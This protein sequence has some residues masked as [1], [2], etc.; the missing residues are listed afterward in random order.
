MVR[1]GK[2]GL[3]CNADRALK[4]HW[5][6]PMSIKSG[7]KGQSSRPEMKSGRKLCGNK[8]RFGSSGNSTSKPKSWVL[9][10]KSLARSRG[11]T[12]G[13]VSRLWLIWG[14]AGSCNEWTNGSSIASEWF[15]K[16]SA[17]VFLAF[18]LDD[19]LVSTAGSLCLP[20]AGDLAA[21]RDLDSHEKAD[22]AQLTL[23]TRQMFEALLQEENSSSNY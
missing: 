22:P 5:G 3:N 14:V 11:K 16:G 17:A 19:L 15:S 20:R 21:C 18:D 10:L 1:G 7:S 9:S 2:W 13:S 4:V 8:S 6:Y 12:G 23:S